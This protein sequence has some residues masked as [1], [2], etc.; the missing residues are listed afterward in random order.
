[1]GDIGIGDKVILVS[2]YTSESIYY[3]GNKFEVLLKNGM[4]GFP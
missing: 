1:M 4:E 2:P 3:V